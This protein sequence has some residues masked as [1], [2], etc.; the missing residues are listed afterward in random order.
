MRI[1]AFAIAIAM[2]LVMSA[3]ACSVPSS[4]ANDHKLA[5][6]RRGHVTV[7][8]NKTRSGDPVPTP[9]SGTLDIVQYVS[10]AGSLAAYLSPLPKDGRKHPAIIWISGGDSNSIGDFWTPQDP[11][12]DQTAMAFRDA[13]I[14]EMYPSLR[15]GNTNPGYREGMYG[16][17][18]DILAAADFLA[19]QPGVDPTRIYLGGHSTGGTLVLLTAEMNARFRA[20]FAFGPISNPAEYGRVFPL[21]VT[22][23]AEVKLRSPGEWLES[24]SSPVFVLEGEGG[25][26]GPLQDMR[27][28]N[29][30]PML[31]FLLVPRATH[32]SVLAPATALIANRILADT[33]A[34]TNIDLTQADADKLIR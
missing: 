17:V 29:R 3:S 30:N 12:N 27:A 6:A 11:S 5:D 34:R 15:G 9:P 14:V 4:Q 18:D 31:H 10:P 24:V 32:F 13:G 22:D 21:P 25:N 19:R 7:L 16:E 23:P 26:A 8:A 2:A 33:G 1:M 28:A 20:V